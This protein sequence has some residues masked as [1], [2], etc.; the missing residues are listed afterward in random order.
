MTEYQRYILTKAK[1]YCSYQERCLH[2]VKTK[3]S[4]W[5]AQPKVS[6]E[7]IAQLIQDDYINEERFARNFAVG[8]FRQKKWGKNKIIHALKLKQIP[9]LIIQIGLEA[10]DDEEYT[11]TLVDLLKKKSKEIK[12]KNHHRRNYKL[13]AYAIRKGFRPGLVW[14]V[15][16]QL[17]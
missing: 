9:D 14:D 16:Y 3:L 12:D 11:R 17:I 6:D 15:V 13:A 8:K 7:I 2:D 10:I 4:E 1:K 5:Q